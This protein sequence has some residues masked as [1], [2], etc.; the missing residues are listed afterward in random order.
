M[1]KTIKLDAAKADF[2]DT[3]VVAILRDQGYAEHKVQAAMT[4]VTYLKLVDDKKNGRHILI[5]LF[6]NKP[7]VWFHYLYNAKNMP[8]GINYEER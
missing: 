7:F 3:D 1:F 6:R 2:I 5:I 4:R 8:C